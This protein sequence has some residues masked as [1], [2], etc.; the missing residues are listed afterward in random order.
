M[1]K[2]I[3]N[4]DTMKITVNGKVIKAQ[5]GT[6]VLDVIEDS[7]A[8]AMRIDGELHDLSMPITRDCELELVDFSSEQGQKIY[9][10]SSSHVMAM[11]VK[12]LFPKAKL[13]IGPAIDQGFYYD[14]DV[15]QPFTPGD[16][17]KIEKEM[18]EI[19]K[20]NLPFDRVLMNKGAAIDMFERMGESY[21]VELINEIPDDEVSVYRNGGFV[22]LCRGPHVP[23]TGYIKAFKLLSVA[24]AYWRGDEHQPMLSRIYGIS[25][26]SED[27]LTVYLDTLEEAKKRDHRRLG[28]ELELFSIFDEA[29][30]GLVHWHPK[31]AT[32][33]RLIEE[34]WVEEHLATGYQIV[35]TPHIARGHLWHTS[36][37]YDFYRDKM[38]TVPIEKEEYVLKPMNCPGHILIYKSKVRSYKDLPIKLAEIGTVYRNELSGTLHGL[39]RVRSITIDDAHVFCQPSQIEDELSKV[40]GLAKKM[41]NKF[42]FE[43]F[44]VDLSVRDPHK[45]DKYMGSDEEWE[46]AEQ[47]L[48]SALKRINLDAKRMEGEAVFYGPKIDIKL[49]DALG[50]EWQATTIQFDFN[51]PKR[52]DITYMDRDG[53]RKEVVV[54]HRAIYGSLERFIGCLIEHYSGA[55]PLWLAPVQVVVM[56]ITNKEN[57]YAEKVYTGCL[58]Q[59]LRVELDERS[60]KIGARVRN[61][62]VQ[63]VPYSLV[64]GKKEVEQE[65]VSVRKHGRV[66]IGVMKLDEFFGMIHKELGGEN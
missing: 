42:G 43:K 34:H 57:D 39:L 40:L 1:I 22:D 16:L 51:L 26:P 10:H 65:T 18:K 46:R 32:L 41:L 11:A 45:K 49:L 38:F 59:G 66:T 50:R 17:E 20:Q 36:G 62:E 4:Y 5:K 15:A 21:K 52:F 44:R 3:Y 25:F 14:F 8:L 7:R 24:G 60:D 63:K 55:F 47:G 48:V 30:A 29:G 23:D 64:V 27:E 31:G 61:A 6:R 35:S 12:S 19:I 33:K 54:I 37:H 9:W 28:V 2:I 53:V 58:K 56:P 13:A